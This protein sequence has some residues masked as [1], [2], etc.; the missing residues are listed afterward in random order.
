MAVNRKSSKKAAS[1]K[2]RAKKKSSR[3]KTTSNAAAGNDT[4]PK[5][6]NIALEHGEVLVRMYDIGFGDCF[7]IVYDQGSRRM[8]L[9]FD[10]GSITKRKKSTADIVEQLLDDITEENGRKR[11]DLIVATHRHADHVSGFAK[12]GWD[13]VEVGEVWMPWVEHPS[14][15]VARRIRTA[16]SS[17]ALALAGALGLDASNGSI[18]DFDEDSA[19]ASAFMALNALSNEDA[20]NTLHFGFL[21]TTRRRFLPRGE[22]VGERIVSRRIPGL[23]AHI[24]GPSK[25]ED[26]IRDMDPPTDQS[27]FALRGAGANGSL[28]LRPFKD[29]WIWN[30]PPP[31]YL[32]EEER[33]A[34]ETV[35]NGMDG[36]LAVAID[37]AVNG[38]SLMIML[39]IHGKFLLFPGDAQWGTWKSAMEDPDGKRL[40]RK[41]TF[42]KVGHHGSH[43]STPVD[44]VEEILK[45]EGKGNRSAMVSVRPKSQWK[46]IP[47][48]P[49]IT[50]LKK[51]IGSV[52][53][54]DKTQEQPGF[55]R[56]GDWYVEKILR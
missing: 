7:L 24:L 52:A 5:I 8:K 36:A 18:T 21:G 41:T 53:Q 2:S 11:I 30:G 44:F 35:N 27:Y 56:N 33:D 12:E 20:M 15:P 40:L 43:N 39:Q 16:Q 50:E 13:G 17:F 3:K 23:V 32:T 54:S 26:V 25:N 51:R 10:C 46:H 28:D 14:D 22:G 9:L 47:R 34:I 19:D 37:K 45:K 48:K 49:L 31:A 4:T 6:A 55:E 42:Y 29:E 1:K 38:T